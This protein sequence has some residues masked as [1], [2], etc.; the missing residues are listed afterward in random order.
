M[1]GGLAARLFKFFSSIHPLFFSLLSLLSF[2][3]SLVVCGYCMFILVGMML[4]PSVCLVSL[5]SSSLA[6]PFSRSTGDEL[7]AALGTGV[8][9]GLGGALHA[10]AETA[11][12]LAVHGRINFGICYKATITSDVIP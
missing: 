1:S 10:G 9:T 4:F 3:H 7:L 8:S 11:A 12:N 2:T 6:A 5:L